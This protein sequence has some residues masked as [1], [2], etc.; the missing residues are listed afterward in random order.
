[1]FAITSTSCEEL[2]PVL[3]AHLYTVCPMTIPAMSLK[4][5]GNSSGGDES[6]LMESLGMLKDKNGEYESFDKFLSRTGNERKSGPRIW[7][8]SHLLTFLRTVPSEGLVSIMADIMSSLP[9]EHTLLG[10]RNGA[11]QW[12]ERFMDTL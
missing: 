3:E 9:A 1:M 11:V 6:D 2:L 12:I 5:D 10:G 4:G 7:N 8:E